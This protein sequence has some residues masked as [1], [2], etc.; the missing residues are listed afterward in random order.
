VALPVVNRQGTL[1]PLTVCAIEKLAIHRS[2]SEGP[3]W[4]FLVHERF[5]VSGGGEAGPTGV[6][7]GN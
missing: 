1:S 2:L 7:L 4:Y 3:T 5:L 6:F